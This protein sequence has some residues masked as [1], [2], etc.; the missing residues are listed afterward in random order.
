MKGTRIQSARNSV[1]GEDEGYCR[2]VEWTKPGYL[3]NILA[4]KSYIDQ[5]SSADQYT[6]VTRGFFFFQKD[7]LN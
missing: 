6:T 1:F 5:V 2:K 7:A 4:A 3:K